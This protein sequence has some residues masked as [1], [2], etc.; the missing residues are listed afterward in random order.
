V[1]QVFQVEIVEAPDYSRGGRRGGVWH[2][3]N[4]RAAKGWRNKLL[5]EIFDLAP[6]TDEDVLYEQSANISIIPITVYGRSGEPIERNDTWPFE[7]LQ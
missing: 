4:E 5:R 2:F 1:K 3:T 6:D 7:E